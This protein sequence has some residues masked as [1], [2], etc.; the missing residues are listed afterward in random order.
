MIWPMSSSDEDEIY[1][2]IKEGSPVPPPPPPTFA[3]ARGESGGGGA[4]PPPILR[5]SWFQGDDR[6]DQVL[7]RPIPRPRWS[8]RKVTFG[9]CRREFDFSGSAPF[10]RGRRGRPG[11]LFM[12]RFLNRGSRRLCLIMTHDDDGA[13]MEVSGTIPLPSHI[14]CLS[15]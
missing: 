10:V 12:P 7:P 5:L 1:S 4:P 14:T 9:E 8:N 15:S 6:E 3:R 2:V 13:R 11:E